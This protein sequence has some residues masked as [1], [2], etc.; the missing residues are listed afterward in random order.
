MNHSLGGVGGNQNMLWEPQWD[1][2][3]CNV[4]K[5]GV[6]R[7]CSMC[8]DVPVLGWE[9]TDP[10]VLDYSCLGWLPIFPDKAGGI[11]AP[12]ACL[13]RVARSQ[14]VTLD[15]SSWY[16]GAQET[17]RAT[18]TA[19]KAVSSCTDGS[20]PVLWDMTVSHGTVLIQV[21]R[22]IFWKK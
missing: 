17:P 8:G 19:K 22:A 14:P 2:P 13:A 5:V 4:L 12:C 3:G 6:F 11:S 10:I 20:D 1:A 15:Q 7:P 16:L 18:A 9:V 21:K